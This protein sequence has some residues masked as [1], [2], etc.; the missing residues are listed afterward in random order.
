MKLIEYKKFKRDYDVVIFAEP[1][2]LF[3]KPKYKKFNKNK[4]GILIE[5]E[6]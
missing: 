1:S 2:I 3:K 4:N 5:V 6:A